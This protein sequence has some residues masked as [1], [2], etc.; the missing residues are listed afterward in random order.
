MNRLPDRVHSLCVG[1]P[2]QAGEQRVQV[3]QR[4]RQAQLLRHHLPP[5]FPTSNYAASKPELSFFR[6]YKFTKPVTI[7]E[8]HGLKKIL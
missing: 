1:R 2:G 6:N 8:I 4:H 3:R 7:G 5:G